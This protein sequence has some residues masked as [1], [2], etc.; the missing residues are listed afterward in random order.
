MGMAAGSWS[1]PHAML[2][3]PRPAPCTPHPAPLIP[4]PTPCTPILLPGPRAPRL[5]RLHEVLQVHGERGLVAPAVLLQPAQ[6]L[7]MSSQLT[8][9]SRAPK[10]ILNAAQTG[11]LLLAGHGQPYHTA[12][13]SL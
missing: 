13:V 7:A 8:L 6:A 9:T 5:P 2:A 3:A 1:Y 10:T 4:H 12:T 11:L